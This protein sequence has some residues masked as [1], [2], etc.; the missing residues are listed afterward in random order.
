MRKGDLDHIVDDLSDDEGDEEAALKAR[1][2]MELREDKEMT[3]KVITAVT[4]GHDA[5]RRQNKKKGFSFEHLVGE[6]KI[7]QENEGD[8]EKAGEVEEELDEEEMLIRGMNQRAEMEKRNRARR[9][10]GDDSDEEFDEDANSD[11]EFEMMEALKNMSDEQKAIEVENFQRKR[12]MER[13]EALRRKQMVANFQMRRQLRKEA[14][15]QQQVLQQ[16]QSEGNVSAPTAML[17][18]VMRDIT[19]SSIIRPSTLKLQLKRSR[20]TMQAPSMPTSNAIQR[21]ATAPR[22]GYRGELNKMEIEGG[23]GMGMA[24]TSSGLFSMV[25]ANKGKTGLKRSYS[26]LHQLSAA[27]GKSVGST[28][29]TSHFVY[30][31]TSSRHGASNVGNDEDYNQYSLPADNNSMP[32]KHASK[33]Q[34]TKSNPSASSC[35]INA[36]IATSSLFAKLGAKSGLLKKSQSFI[37]P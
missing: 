20:T 31:D 12:E 15:R 11:M 13:A 35:N 36:D 3:R 8:E 9:G 37:A 2:E 19:N 25:T 18:P 4:E 33:L 5:L 23:Y 28:V 34:R 26:S 21:T 1:A 29:A 24:V 22:N 10:N 30:M 27:G 32:S 7:G 6:K 14:A 16:Q 17:P